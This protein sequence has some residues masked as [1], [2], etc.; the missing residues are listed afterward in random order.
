VQG[1]FLPVYVFKED[2]RNIA[3]G[4]DKEGILEYI[5]GHQAES[6]LAS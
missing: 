1:R 3:F 5:R 2:G 4:T 6:K